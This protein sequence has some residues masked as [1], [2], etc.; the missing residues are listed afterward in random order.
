MTMTTATSSRP[1]LLLPI[2]SKLR[3]RLLRLKPEGDLYGSDGS[4]GMSGTLSSGSTALLFSYLEEWIR[5]RGV[6]VAFTDVGAAF[7]RM[8]VLAPPLAGACMATGVEISKAEHTPRARGGGDSKKQKVPSPM[9]SLFDAFMNDA[10]EILG[11]ERGLL[12]R[13]SV[14]LTL[15]TN[16]AELRSKAYRMPEPHRD[17]PVIVYIFGD[18]MDETDLQTILRKCQRCPQVEL[19]LFAP[20]RGEGAVLKASRLSRCVLKERDKNLV[21]LL[22][23]FNGVP[24]ATLP[25]NRPRPSS[26]NKKH[27]KGPGLCIQGSKERKKLFVFERDGVSKQSGWSLEQQLTM[28]TPSNSNHPSRPPPPTSLLMKTAAD[29]AAETHDDH[30]EEEEEEAAA[31]HADAHVDRPAAA[32]MRQVAPNSNPGLGRGYVHDS[33]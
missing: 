2:D 26:S 11:R 12:L 31:D 16:A 27:K 33:P 20:C 24:Q 9:R 4:G 22:P 1:S 15:G 7:G 14:R 25:W 17:M 10:C 5:E 19:V 23:S 3:A 32:G 18:G 29:H 21:K 28:V 8:C 13:Q 6:D 30:D